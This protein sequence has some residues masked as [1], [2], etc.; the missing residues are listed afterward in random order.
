VFFA[1]VSATLGLEGQTQLT[2]LASVLLDISKQIPDNIDWVLQVEGPTDNV[3][4]ATAQ[5]PSNWELS[6]ARAIQ[7]VRQLMAAGIPAR[8]LAAAGYADNYPIAQ[9]T[10]DA[11]RSQNRRIELKLTQR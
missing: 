6:A 1:S 5:C 11:G 2:Q 7:V 3:P 10:S 8:R 9:N 4:I